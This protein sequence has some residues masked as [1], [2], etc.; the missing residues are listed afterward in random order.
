MEVEVG[1][2]LVEED[3]PACRRGT[4]GAGDGDVTRTESLRGTRG[5]DFHSLERYALLMGSAT[6]GGGKTWSSV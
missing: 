3:E 5:G 2:E 1:L 6:S 4:S